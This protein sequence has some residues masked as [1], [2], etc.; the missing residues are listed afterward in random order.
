MP[1]P[2]MSPKIDKVLVLAPGGMS[3]AVA[4]PAGD[5]D[6]DTLAAVYTAVVSQDVGNGSTPAIA[7]SIG[8]SGRYL[9]PAPVPAGTPPPDLRWDLT[10]HVVGGAP[11]EAGGATCAAWALYADTDGGSW[12][13]EWR[14]PVRLVEAE[15]AR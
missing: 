15:A 3:V 5:W 13:Y 9:P 7:T 2:M 10:A 11:L 14:L 8:W 1:R 12:V 4:G 6:T